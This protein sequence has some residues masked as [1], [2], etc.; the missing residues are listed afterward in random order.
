MAA[1]NSNIQISNVDF[2]SIK[3][4]LRTFLQGQSTFRDYDFEGSGLAVLLDLMAYNTHYNS[5]Y[6]NMVANEMFMDTAAL[7]NSVVS[8]AKLLNYTPHSAT[9]PSAVINIKANEVKD[10][11]VSIPTFT[12]FSSEAIDGT[13]YTFV[14]KN[15]YTQPVIN[16]TAS[17]D[18]VEIVQ[19]E[20]VALIYVVNVSTNPKQIF[21]ISDPNIDTATLTVRVQK[22]VSDSTLSTYNLADDILLLDGNSEV[23]FL[24]EGLNGNY[25]IYF[26]DNILGKYLDDGNVILIDYISTSGSMAA[27]ANNFVLLDVVGSS[28][29][30][31]YPMSAASAGGAKESIDSIKF[32]APKAYSAQNRA[33]SFEDY[34]T[35]I[36][37]NKLGFAIDS[38]NV[39][40]GEDNS[41]PA[42][43]QV[44]ISV[45]P[46]GG[47]YL[48]D[49]QKNRLRDEVVKPVS[50]VT[51][52]PTVLDPD[53]TYLKITANVLYD[54]KKTILTASQMQSAI[55]ASIQSFA[56]ASLN[57]FNSTFSLSDLTN[58]IQSTSP[59]I[60]SNDSVIKVQ[61]KFYPTIGVSKQYV[62][63]YGIP[64][65]RSVFETGITSNP[66]LQYYTTGANITLLNDVYLEETP[67]PTS[68]IDN[69]N[70]LN[71]GYNYTQVPTVQILGDGSGATAHAVV[72]NGYISKIV[73]DTPGN[74]YTQ[75]I[76]KIVNATGDTSGT[77]GSAYA[78][79]QG[80]YGAIR[81]YYYENNIKTI[82]NN[83]LGVIDY[84]TGIVTLNN[85]V[86]ADVNEPLGQFTL[87]ANPLSTVISSSQ[88]RIITV[89]PFDSTAITV[90]VTAK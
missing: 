9:A 13:N 47:Y 81:S 59:S 27:G 60:I 42:Y 44:F 69:I 66:S 38:V 50:V 40:G 28:N 7:R 82:L 45:K 17:F 65:N 11:S 39:W 54:Q 26:G 55:I 89:D 61:K 83:S 20:P 57:S 24:Q 21:E 68:G 37:Q 15:T 85:F 76:V 87:T 56:D 71:P 48:T 23:Y 18:N 36:Q 25:Q 70:I 51:V 84:Q 58:A 14:T 86:P 10:A 4:N 63:N 16:G 90:N 52:Q 43:G 30:V 78:Q 31:I 88:N 34:I 49:N 12:K 41:P 74:N 79:L 75:V 72:K 5:Y 73:V 80:R 8:H 33:V 32:Q 1:S 19:G 2:D 77:N 22:S 62:L 29:T 3:N 6:L 53:Y 46:K 67:F 35:A 64:L